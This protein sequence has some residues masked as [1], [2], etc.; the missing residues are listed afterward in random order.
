MSPENIKKHFPESDEMPT[1][2]MRQSRQGVRST[3]VIDEDKELELGPLQKPGMK[4]KD[5]YLRI[6]EGTKHKDVYL[7][8]FDATKKSMYTD[9][10]GRFPIT[11][12]RGNKY[13]MV[14]VELDG[15]YIDA[16]P[17]MM[18]TTKDLIEAY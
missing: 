6:F 8:I 2:H 3:K 12:R 7:R 17:L 15:N 13:Q 14:A 18:R 10:T 1:G 16:E 4:H 5:V 9:Q 11:L